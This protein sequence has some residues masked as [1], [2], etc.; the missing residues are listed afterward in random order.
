MSSFHVLAID[1]PVASGKGTVA[2]AVAEALGFH[3]LDSGAIYRAFALS[4]QKKYIN[5][6]NINELAIEAKALSLKFS[7]EKVILNGADATAEI[8]SEAVGMLASQLSS[9]PEV[10]AALLERQR[11]FAKAPG[12]IADGRDMG[13]VVFPS[14]PL[15]I[16]LTA[17]AEVRGERRFGQLTASN[18]DS[19]ASTPALAHV[20]A[21]IR[22]RDY[23]DKSRPIAPLKPAADA[24]VID[25]ARQSKQAT[26]RSILA[27]WA[28]R[29]Q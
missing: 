12:L 14:A 18:G 23:Q 7:S 21:Q 4:C 6:L 8:R 19:N 1:G 3:L 15:K 2:R 25:N 26:I 11:A 28:M 17:T 13:T 29:A 20:V 24:I 9:I 22:R 10:R 16:F 5:H 27:L